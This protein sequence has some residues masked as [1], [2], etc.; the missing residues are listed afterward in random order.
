MGTLG[1]VMTSEVSEGFSTL[2]ANGPFTVNQH[3]MF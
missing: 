1:G 3:V 2:G